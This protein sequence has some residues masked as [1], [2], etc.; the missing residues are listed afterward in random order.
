M[1][2]F[3]FLEMVKSNV[4]KSKSNILLLHFIML[5]KDAIC[6]YYS[7]PRVPCSEERHDNSAA[8]KPVKQR[9]RML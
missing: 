2:I 9:G 1:V 4:P 8:S 5:D 7:V 6:L 3:F